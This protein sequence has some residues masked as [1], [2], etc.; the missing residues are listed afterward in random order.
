MPYT[1]EA[2]KVTDDAT[3][4]VISAERR[5]RV[6]APLRDGLGTIH[7]KE[8][9]MLSARIV[10]KV[11]FG[12]GLS[13]VNTVGDPDLTLTN[14]LFDAAGQDIPVEAT[15][16]VAS[17]GAEDMILIQLAEIGEV[18]GTPKWVQAIRNGPAG[19][20]LLELY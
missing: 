10:T 16:P 1:P 8:G 9:D 5:S 2:V 7:Y 14:Y 12:K 19:W 4:V 3:D 6:T 18:T 20:D 15:F 17:L 13:D 11:W